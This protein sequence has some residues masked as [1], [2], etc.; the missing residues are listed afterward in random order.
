M[1]PAIAVAAEQLLRRAVGA[2]VR[3]TGWEPLRGGDRSKV[4]R[5]RV[6]GGRAGA[7]ASVVVKTAVV[8][9]GEDYAPDARGTGP[10]WRLF[11]EWA[12][13]E[14]LG[15]LEPER[16][17]APRLYGGDRAAGVLVVEDVR[18]GVGLDRLLVG[19]DPDAAEDALVGHAEAL[20]RLHAVTAAH[21]DEYTALR[22]GL[23]PLPPI[24]V[25]TAAEAALDGQGLVAGFRRA[26]AELGVGLGGPAVEDLERVAAM[27][28]SPAVRA[29]VHGDAC[30]DNCRCASDGVRLVDFEF[31]GFGHPLIDGACPRLC[32]P[33]CWCAGA[34]P[35]RVV[36]RVEAAYRAAVVG[37]CVWAADDVAFGRALVEG[38]AYWTVGMFAWAVPALFEDD[39]AWGLASGRQRVLHRLGLFDQLSDERRHLQALGSAARGLRARLAARWPEAAPLSA[40]PAFRQEQA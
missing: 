39:V 20:G 28:E 36:R 30:P 21:E 12:S 29:L 35:E 32:Y 15:R 14:L 19:D 4:W 7:P 13:L 1:R 18:A 23:G 9:D 22:A 40:F 3:L 33:S 6:R 11:N 2:A 10:A 5:A 24:P 16:R 25:S 17:L 31:G 38:C 8:A 26:A 34:L 37:G 27:W